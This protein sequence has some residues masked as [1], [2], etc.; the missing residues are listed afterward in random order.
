MAY[1]LENVLGPAGHVIN[2][3]FFGGQSKPGDMGTY[4]SLLGP[5]GHVVNDAVG[6]QGSEGWLDS[7]KSFFM[8]TPEGIQLFQRF[9]PEQQSAFSQLLQGGLQGL[10][11]P[12]QG[13][14]DI[15]NEAN[16]NFQSN[17]IPSILQQFAANGGNKNSSGLQGALG[18]AGAQLQGG[19]AAMKQQF[20]DTNRRTALAQTGLGLQ[21]QFESVLRPKQAGFG[22]TA[23]NTAIKVLPY[24]I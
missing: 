2:N 23:L 1:G 14:E 12:H 17:T 8:G 5:A 9:T 19:L 15:A 6:G 7:I 4:Q 16:K 3:S 20:G 22:E 10:Q 21:P 18:A 11:N 13:F 24:F